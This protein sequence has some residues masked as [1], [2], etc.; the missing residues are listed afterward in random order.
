MAFAATG[1]FLYTFSIFLTKLLATSTDRAERLLHVGRGFEKVDVVLSTDDKRS[2]LHKDIELWR[3]EPVFGSLH[4]L[5][6]FSLCCLRTGLLALVLLVLKVFQ[7]Q[8]FYI[9]LFELARVNTTL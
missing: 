9:V 5:V 7:A 2:L 1:F 6:I 8:S 4:L 3:V